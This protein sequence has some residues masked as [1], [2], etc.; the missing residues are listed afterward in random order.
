MI[1]NESN[2]KSGLLEGADDIDKYLKKK[3]MILNTSSPKITPERLTQ[4]MTR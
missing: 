2:K 3:I 1:T 4:K